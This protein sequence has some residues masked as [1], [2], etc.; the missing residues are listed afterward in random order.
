[1]CIGTSSCMFSCC[2]VSPYN[3]LF[4]FCK[5]LV[6]AGI[7]FNHYCLGIFDLILTLNIVFY[8]LTITLRCFIYFFFNF[9][10][11]DVCN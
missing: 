2:L 5:K 11:S 1:M 9:Y 4:Q 10:G 8:V 3:F 7:S 6:F